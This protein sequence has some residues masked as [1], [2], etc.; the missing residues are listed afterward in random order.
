VV[1]GQADFTSNVANRGGAAGANTLTVSYG[2]PPWEWEDFT[3]PITQC[4]CS[5]ARPSPPPTGSG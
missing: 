3:S 5:A 4:P 2:N 1:V